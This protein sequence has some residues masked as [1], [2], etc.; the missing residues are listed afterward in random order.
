MR[1]QPDRQKSYQP[2]T[3]GWRIFRSWGSFKAFVGLVDA[4]D[5]V[6]A[7]EIHITNPD[8][9]KHLIAEIRD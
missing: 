9:Q 2:P 6:K 4:P 7:I 3:P 8:H 5:E 1:P